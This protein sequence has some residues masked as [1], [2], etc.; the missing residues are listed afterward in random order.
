MHPE[1][2]GNLIMPGNVVLK[3]VRSIV[4]L[5]G[6]LP[7]QE[8]TS[9]N[10]D[11][12]FYDRQTLAGKTKWQPTELEYGHFWMLRD[13][14][15]AEEKPILSN[16]ELIPEKEARVFPPLSG[17]QCLDKTHPDTPIDI[18]SY[19]LRKNRTRDPSAQC[20]LVGIAFRD[21]GYNMLNEWL[22][23]FQQAM[24]GND[25]VETVRL[26]LNEGYINRYF[27]RGIV[28]SLMRRNTPPAELSS[29]WIYFA[30][31]IQEKF[32]DPLRAHNLLPGYVYLLDGIGRVRFAASGPASAE[33]VER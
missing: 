1:S 5:L 9:H 22:H 15:Q 30:T 28:T 33:E 21:Y 16:A 23:P 29:T 26:N 2:V 6:R 8:C 32:R 14:R 25:R 24:Q 17:L 11:V 20:T 18:P 19:W 27:L 13:L 3:T 31:D 12:L 7:I 10:A 4:W